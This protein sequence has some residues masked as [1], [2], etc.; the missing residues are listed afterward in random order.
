VLDQV[1]PQSRFH[2][3]ARIA[4]I[5]IRAGWLAV[6]EPAAQGGQGGAPSAAEVAGAARLLGEL[7]LAGDTPAV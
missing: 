7:R 5:R 3:A 4:V 1:P 2:D 6:A